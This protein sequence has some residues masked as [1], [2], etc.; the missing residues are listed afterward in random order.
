MHA[1]F[2]REMKERRSAIKRANERKRVKDE[3]TKEII[4][5]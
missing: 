3:D 4:P 5:R 2:Y 1:L